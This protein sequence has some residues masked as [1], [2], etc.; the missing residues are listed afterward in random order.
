MIAYASRAAGFPEEF[1]VEIKTFKDE[2]RTE[3]IRGSA[4][5]S[6]VSPEWTTVSIP[7]NAMTGLLDF[8][9]P[10]VWENPAIS[11]K[12]LDEFVVYL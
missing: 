12:A 11:R 7:L 10:K 8:S 1:K 4:V 9:N 6:N 2:A 5:V 3:R